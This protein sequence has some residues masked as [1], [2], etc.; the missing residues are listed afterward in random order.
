MIMI[1]KLISVILVATLAVAPVMA[2]GAS[3]SKTGS[4]PS[5]AQKFI[6]KLAAGPV[7]K[8]SHIG[9]LAVKVSGD[10]VAA[11]NPFK[12][13][14][15]ASNTKLIS[16]GL[17]IN[18]LGPD[19][20]FETKLAH[21]GY[22]R[23]GVLYGDL[24]IV[25]GGDPTIA[26]ADSIALP[27]EALMKKWVEIIGNAGIKK[28]NGM[29]VGDGRF[30]D[31]EFWPVS[32]QYEDM[33]TYYGTGGRGLSFYRNT[34]DI[35]VAAGARVG[36]PITM[37]VDYPKTPWMTFYDE[38]KTGEAGTGDDLFLYN[39]EFAPIAVMRGTFAVDR[40]PKT[41][42]CSNLYPELTCAWYLKEYLQNAG[43]P[44]AGGAGDIG[45][46]G[47][48]RNEPLPDKGLYDA[49]PAQEL[50]VIGSTFSPTVE[51]IARVTN[52]RSDNYYAETLYRMIGRTNE[53]SAAYAACCSAEYKA[54]AKI[55][56][57]TDEVQIRDGSGLSREDYITPEFFCNFLKAM[58][59][60]RNYEA[61]MRTI[62][63]PGHGM[64]EYRLAKEPKALKE[65]IRY[66]SGSIG[67]VLSYSGYVRP[68][69]GK[70]EDTI[71]F[72]VIVNNCLASYDV[73]RPMLDRIVALIAAEN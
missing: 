18:E 23:E 25:G 58:M 63:W 33:G 34:Q 51:Q 73:L 53:G 6:D 7:F 27:E 8:G 61:Y 72:S 55:G 41:E 40:K 39:T 52:W 67:G 31:G 16:T 9:V 32:W 66:K 38:S 3:A 45:P 42:N 60:T 50:T 29:V 44:V 71:V 20:R 59:S 13:L 48:V 26:S 14:M 64:Y 1:K 36:D 56:V 2:Q 69:S 24:Y 70:T 28:I 65:R 5:E 49:T 19:F 4:R 11:I 43:I 30:F 21:S 10:T 57:S 37:T 62:G 68:T 17:A 22:I 54:L 15:P 47:K 46:D 12:R 35:S